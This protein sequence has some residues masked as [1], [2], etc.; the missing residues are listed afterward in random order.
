M[1]AI[2][3]CAGYATRLYPLTLDKPKS[4]LPINGNPIL[5]YTLEKLE[6]INEI[7]S[8][9][10]VSNSKFYNH[11]LKWSKSVSTQK[12][13]KI[14]DNGTSSNGDRLG[15]IGD[16]WFTI[17]REGI[18]DDILVILGDNLFDFR[19]KPMTD[20]FKTHNKTA[21]GVYNMKDKQK[22]KTMGVVSV[23]DNKVISFEDRPENPKSNLASTG[24]YIFSRDDIP[25]IKEYINSGKKREGPGFLILY[26]LKDG[27]YAHLFNGKWYDI[28]TKEVYNKIKYNWN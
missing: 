12:K 2:I 28:G 22:L 1:K 13:L 3:L 7:D 25:K 18:N 24:L 11:F 5:S 14:I 23:K 16:M 6:E 8:I 9:Y 4:L 15:G 19:I 20:F 26:W 10:V 17:E 21:L 27:I